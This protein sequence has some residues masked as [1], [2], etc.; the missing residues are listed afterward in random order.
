MK[1]ARLPH[2]LAAS[3]AVGVALAAPVAPA[4]PSDPQSREAL[5]LL[6][7]VALSAEVCGFAVTDAE[8]DKIA[9]GM[10]TMMR[11]LEL[12]DE[13]ADEFYFRIEA[14]ME[15]EGWERLC[16]PDGEWARTFKAALA[17]YAR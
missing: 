1:S 9:A 16:A 3:L 6:Y 17:Q 12:S 10:D 13:N 7:R 2:I 5:R 14:D 15:R 8:A 4:A 11:R